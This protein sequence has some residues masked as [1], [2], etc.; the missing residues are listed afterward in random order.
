MPRE[1]DKT[2]QDF[3]GI[4]DIRDNT[5]VLKDKSLRAALFISSQNFALKSAE[6]QE[7]TIFQFQ[8]FLNSLDFPCQILVQSR[9]TNLAG[10]FQQL[11]E[12]KINQ[13]N[14]LLKVQIQEYIAFIE[15][16]LKGGGIMSK[17]FFVIVPF[18]LSELFGASGKE[19]LTMR[20][21][22]ENFERARAQLFQRA[23]FVALGLQRAGLQSV[24]LDTEEIIEL[25]WSL[26]HTKEAEQQEF[27][28]EIP[29]EL[30]K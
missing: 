17:N 29:P 4:E 22:E 25:F 30:I 1:N 13:Q 26:Y 6:E 10:Y 19:K 8:S 16:L 14:P 3:I 18:Y 12:Y 20:L 11:E 15:E 28:P 27:F 21:T 2:T 24:L 9:R 7:A 23:E 5:I